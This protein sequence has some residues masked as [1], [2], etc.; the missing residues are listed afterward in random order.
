MSGVRA[1]EISLGAVGL[2]APG[3]AFPGF[4]SSGAGAGAGVLPSGL[5]RPV[6][7][8]GLLT[9]WNWE[10]DTNAAPCLALASSVVA[11]ISRTKTVKWPAFCRILPTS[12]GPGDVATCA[13]GA[14]EGAF[15]GAFTGV[16]GGGIAGAAAGD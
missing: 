6:F 11:C 4:P 12:T 14:C 15:S 7:L 16:V 8:Q 10:D 13:D 9:V 5:F 2:S 1:P 3:A